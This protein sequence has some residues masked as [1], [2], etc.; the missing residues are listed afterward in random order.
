MD[1][2]T[3]LA[4][5]NLWVVEEQPERGNLTRLNTEE[6]ELYNLLRDN[7]LG[8]KI[9]LEQERIGFCYLKAALDQL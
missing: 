7:S 5:Q 8:N 9:R 1:Q 3:L 4:H 2:R 6:A